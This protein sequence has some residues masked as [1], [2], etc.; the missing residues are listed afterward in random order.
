MGSTH[1]E[2][3]RR[4]S[5]QHPL[6]KSFARPVHLQHTALAP[7]PS[8]PP[9]LQA[10]R[11][12]R[13]PAHPPPPP[14]LEI[15][16][17]ARQQLVTQKKSRVRRGARHSRACFPDHARAR[18]THPENTER[19]WYTHAPCLTRTYAARTSTA[20]DTH[21]VHTPSPLKKG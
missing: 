19:G 8:P 11:C 13:G 10:V 6:T 7:F 16:R 4:T 20:F 3:K 9:I 17:S 21:G 14:R 5:A 12:D 18:P 2:D 15:D 1:Y